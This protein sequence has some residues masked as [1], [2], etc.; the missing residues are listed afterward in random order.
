MDDVK[1]FI[2]VALLGLAL[3]GFIIPFIVY[4]SVRFGSFAY[5]KSKRDYY[6]QLWFGERSREHG[7]RGETEKRK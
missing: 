1:D 6:Y 5:F 2:W 3:V 7:K 4:F